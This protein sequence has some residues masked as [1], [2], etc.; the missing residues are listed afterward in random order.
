MGQ[1]ITGWVGSSGLNQPA[2]RVVACQAPRPME[3]GQGPIRI[4]V[5]SLRD[6]HIKEPM[7]VLRDLEARR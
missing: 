1:A 6:L 2:I 5:D 4:R 3:H 7:G